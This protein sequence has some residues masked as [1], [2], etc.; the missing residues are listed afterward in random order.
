MPRSLRLEFP[1]A[2]YH[3][4]ARGNRRETIFHDDDDRRFFLA[5]LSEACAMTGWQVHAWVLMGNHY[6]LF[7]ETPEAN[8]VAG[9]SWLQNT[10]TRRH[11][12]RHMAWGRLFGD[13]YK[14]V[15]VDGADTYHYRT[16]VDYIHLN[17]VRARLVLPRKGQSVLDY[18]WSSVAGGWALP[19]GKRPKWLAAGEG[20]KRFDLPDTVAGRRRLVERLDRR[21]VEEE[22]KNCGMP[23]VPEKVDARCSHLRRGWYWGSQEFAGKLHKLAEKLMKERKRSSRAYRKTPQV[24]AHS[25]KQAERL[26]AEGLQAS[27]LAAKDLP[28]LKGSDPR[29]LA[30]A[31][32]LWKRTTVSQEWIAEKLS[33]RSAA[34]VSQQLRRFNRA[35]TQAK[36]RP[37]M[38][39]FLKTAWNT[40]S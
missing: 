19:L 25:E 24:A 11:N 1:G 12:V 35:K 16:L 6:H 15:L 4:M 13:R 36:L 31:E 10:V 23:V 21:A 8:L 3:V 26:L 20:M 37:E 34:N 38:R 17:P 39:V 28:V 40:A 7:I 33:M 30:L 32:L 22:I 5:T 9:M 18:P 27:G 29:K 2:F 14:A